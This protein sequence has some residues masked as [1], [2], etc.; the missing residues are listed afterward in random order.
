MFII[1]L[2]GGKSIFKFIFR[3]TSFLSKPKLANLPTPRIIL[4]IIKNGNKIKLKLIDS[5]LKK[6]KEFE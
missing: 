6:K 1:L 3:L 5:N 2:K 4:K